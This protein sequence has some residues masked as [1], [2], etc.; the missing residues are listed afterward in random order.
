MMGNLPAG[1]EGF[2]DELLKPKLPWRELLRR[3]A[4]SSKADDYTWRWPNRRHIGGDLYLP[5]LH[6]EAMPPMVVVIDTSGSTSEFQEQFGGEMKSIVEEVLPEK[7]VVIYCDCA[8]QKVKT[9]ERGE[10]VLEHHK[11]NGGT[12][13]IPPF[14]YVEKEGIEPACLIYLT[15]LEGNFPEPPPYP[16]MW[17]STTNAVAPFGETVQLD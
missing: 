2:V 9:F 3:F 7:T 5:S 16:V 14:E 17:V 13:F 15:D 4:Q 12:S 10:L 1:I 6:S 11:G 8:V